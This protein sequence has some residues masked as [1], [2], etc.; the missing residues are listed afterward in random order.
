MIYKLL[1][2]TLKPI[3]LFNT[4]F[5]DDSGSGAAERSSKHE[6]A[7]DGTG[8]AAPS[9]NS[10]IPAPS[11]PSL[12]STEPVELLCRASNINSVPNRNSKHNQTETKIHHSFRHVHV[13]TRIAKIHVV[14]KHVY[15]QM[16]LSYM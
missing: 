15:E 7:K 10:L 1:M 2:L 4:Y 16:H 11:V 8:V 6:T 13:S 9:F 12:I 14:T 3:L 5:D